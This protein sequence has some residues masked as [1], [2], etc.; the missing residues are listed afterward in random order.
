MDVIQRNK[1][2]RSFILVIVAFALPIIIAKLA[3]TFGWVEY[4]VTNRGELLEQPLSLAELNIQQPDKE[5]QWLMLYALP[6]N[7]DD[8]CQQLIKGVN[9]T[10]IA[11]GKEMPRVTPVA[12]SLGSLDNHLPQLSQSIRSHDWLFQ[13][14]SI[15]T[16]SELKSQHLYLVDPLGNIFM[17]HQLP[18]ESAAISAFGKAVLADMKKVLKYSKVG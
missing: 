18:T 2:R 10:Y 17:R 15:D 1:S 4:G 16:L 8:L 7:C 5:K 6:Q 3:L 14:A 9:N 11:L 12:L 13:Q